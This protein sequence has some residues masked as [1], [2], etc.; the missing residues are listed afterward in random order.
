MKPGATALTVMP[1]LES[2]RASGLGKADEARLAR[3]V[4]RLAGIASEA[5][6]GGDID[7]AA[8]AL[9]E[10]GAH[11][12]LDEVER[13][14]EIRIE[15][16]I[17]ILLAHAHGEAVARQAGVVHENIHPPEIGEDALADLQRRLCGPPHPRHRRAR[18]PGSSAVQRIRDFGGIAL[19]AADAG[20]F[21]ALAGR[22]GGRWLRRCRVRR[23]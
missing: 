18:N 9:L 2:S 23:R 7:D 10:H 4:I 21:H 8:G 20:D 5:G 6:D 1:R 16:E 15:H 13:A 22:G 12:A 3:G 19:R 17:P 14:L 11:H